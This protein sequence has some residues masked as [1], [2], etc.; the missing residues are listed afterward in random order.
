MLRQPFHTLSSW[1]SGVQP[2]DEAFRAHCAPGRATHPAC[3]SK[4]RA[5]T[6]VLWMVTRVLEH[7][8]WFLRDRG[9]TW[10]AQGRP[11]HETRSTQ[12][13]C[14]RLLRH[15]GSRWWGAPSMEQVTGQ[16]LGP[17]AQGQKVQT[18]PFLPLNKNLS[19]KVRNIKAVNLIEIYHFK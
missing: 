2:L 9:T 11:E 8:Y 18:C 1:N 14:P 17:P 3:G 6:R 19:I 5:S 4:L 10:A 13:G 15:G 12:T 16:A 7:S